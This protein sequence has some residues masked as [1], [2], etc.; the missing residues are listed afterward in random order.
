MAKKAASLT[1]EA[2]GNNLWEYS[3]DEVG[4][5]ALRKLHQAAVCHYGLAPQY[6]TEP[7]DEGIKVLKVSFTAPAQAEGQVGV[8]PNLAKW[9]EMLSRFMQGQ[10]NMK[11]SFSKNHSINPTNLHAVLS[12][13]ESYAS[14]FDRYVE[15][16][17]APVQL[18]GMKSAAQGCTPVAA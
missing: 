4:Y 18:E 5:A 10:P 8:H 6:K 13:L 14:V 1:I 9:E 12:V 7:V 16:F 3:L 15:R 11:L 2:I 17:P